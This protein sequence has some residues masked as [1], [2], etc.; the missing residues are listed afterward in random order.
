[1]SAASSG[2]SIVLFE[3]TYLHDL[4]RILYSMSKQLKRYDVSLKVALTL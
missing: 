3:M 2:G 4:V 1:M